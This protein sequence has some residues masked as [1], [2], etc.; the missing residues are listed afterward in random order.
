MTISPKVTFY[1]SLLL[2]LLLLIL[3]PPSSLLPYSP[4][5][6]ARA[7]IF[8]NLPTTFQF[9]TFGDVPEVLRNLL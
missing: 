6:P 5:P 4:P 8:R 7:Q 3:F 2:H 1:T 9:L